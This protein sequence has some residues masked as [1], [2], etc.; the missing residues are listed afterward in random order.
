MH[1]L[2]FGVH[3]LGLLNYY[4]ASILTHDLEFH[5]SILS[6]ET[7]RL[8]SKAIKIT[9]G[10]L[11]EIQQHPTTLNFESQNCKIYSNSKLA[12][13]CMSFSKKRFPQIYLIYFS[14]NIL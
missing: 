5:V 9:G 11:L 14:F 6:E 8:Q 10:R 1:H 12:N 3:Y 4:L 7:T 2:L 13:L